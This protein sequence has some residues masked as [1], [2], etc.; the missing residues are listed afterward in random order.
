MA[1]RARAPADLVAAVRD[2]AP[3]DH[4][5]PRSYDAATPE[6]QALFERYVRELRV[7]K[8]AADAWWEGLVGK[9]KSAKARA[10]AEAEVREDVPVGPAAHVRAIGVVRK[11]WLEVAALN[12]AAS[13]QTRVAP[14]CL[15]LTW[16]SEAGHHELAAFVGSYPYWP[17]GLDAGGRWV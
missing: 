8:E 13:P 12:R 3:P 6:Q 15:L 1:T 4:P 7:A 5:A 11:F 14:E 16:L 10:K 9:H 2:I 17:V